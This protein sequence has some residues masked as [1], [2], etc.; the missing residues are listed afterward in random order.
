MGDSL[1]ITMAPVDAKSLMPRPSSVPS[2][3]S[4]RSRHTKVE[5]KKNQ[6]PST[7][8]ERPRS[9]QGRTRQTMANI[10]AGVLMPRAEGTIAGETISLGPP[11][12]MYGAAILSRLEAQQKANRESTF[13]HYV[14]TH[15]IASGERRI[16]IDG[17]RLREEENK[18]S[19]KG[20]KLLGGRAKRRLSCNSVGQPVGLRAHSAARC[21]R[22]FSAGAL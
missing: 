7:S 14:K 19:R 11:A 3:K 18:E 12:T 21:R 5:E 16:L 8:P 4:K 15:N 2:S 9:N 10:D 1:R 22:S 6:R 20:E 13:E 17:R